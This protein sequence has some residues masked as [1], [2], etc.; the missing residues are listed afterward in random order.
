[1]PM[2]WPGGMLPP[3]QEPWSVAQVQPLR[4]RH[5]PP[6]QLPAQLPQQLQ[7]QSPG[8]GP[9]GH[10]VSVGGWGGERYIAC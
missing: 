4:R 9:L 7:W 2:L 1:M 3:G 10:L 6:R 5:Q 8:M